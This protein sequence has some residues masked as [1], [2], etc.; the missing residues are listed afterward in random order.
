MFLIH[1]IKVASSTCFTIVGRITEVADGKGFNFCGFYLI[2]Q[3]K[4]N[5]EKLAN[6]SPTA[7][8]GPLQ[9]HFYMKIKSKRNAT[10]PDH[11]QV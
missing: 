6:F 1:K 5:V 7:A 10:S 4:L 2:L 8:K 11:Q 9:E 3:L